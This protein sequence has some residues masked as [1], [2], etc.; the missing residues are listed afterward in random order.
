MAADK[1]LL[2]VLNASTEWLQQRGSA[3]ARLDA[4]L[5]IG[6]ALDLERLQL[7]LNFDRPLNPAELKKARALIKRRGTGEPI[8]YI[9]GY[10]EFHAVRLPVGP[11]VLVPRPETEQLVDLG[12]EHL[13][14]Q[15]DEDAP[16][17]LDLCTG[18]ACIAVAAAVAESE[19]RVVAVDISEQA[20]VWARKAVVEHKLEDRLALRRG[21]LFSAIPQRFL[22]C[23]KVIT[24]NP[25]YIAVGDKRVEAQVTKHE[26]GQALFAGHDGLD[27]V[28]TILDRAARW[29]SDEGVLLIEIGAGQG[30][31]VI[32]LAQDAGFS[33]PQVLDDLAGIGRV[34][35]AYSSGS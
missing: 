30:P 21:D 9:R 12:L 27:V 29:L 35:R 28:R 17:W 20:L 11:G 18:S 34:F 13:K 25:P 1:T 3:S 5:L 26:P 4:E 15:S 22:G 7:Y 23:F 8:A 33:N 6:Q 31:K 10:R 24:A 32:E 2:D 19:L 16:T 14:A